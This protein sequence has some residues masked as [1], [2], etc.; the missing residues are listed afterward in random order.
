MTLG[1]L[2]TKLAVM[3]FMSCCMSI[4]FLE[5]NFKNPGVL[6]SVCGTILT[7]VLTGGL[8]PFFEWVRPYLE[9]KV[10]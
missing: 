6:G 7:Y 1:F 10:V 4:V 9:M 3:I 2:L 8:I 5:L